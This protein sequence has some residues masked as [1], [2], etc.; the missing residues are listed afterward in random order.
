MTQQNRNIGIA[1]DQRDRN[2]KI[3]EGGG[4]ACEKLEKNSRRT[5]RISQHH[6]EILSGK[7]QKLE[8]TSDA[9]LLLRQKNRHDED[10]MHDMA[11]MV[12][13]NLSKLS[14]IGIPT[15]NYMVEVVLL[16]RILNVA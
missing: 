1:I 7:K 4:L 3:G 9:I 8:H 2:C 16:P 6:F 14:G 13:C 15:H 10:D 5:R 11:A 12:Q